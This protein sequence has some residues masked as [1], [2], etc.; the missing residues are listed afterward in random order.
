M[1]T[2]RSS[3]ILRLLGLVSLCVLQNGAFAAQPPVTCPAGAPIST[4]DLRVRSVRGTEPLPLRTINRL[5]EGDA[6][7]YSPI[8]HS[9]EKRK[10]E[11]SVVLVPAKR[12]PDGDKLLVLDPKPAE[13]SAEWKVPTK[14]SVASFVYGPDG[15]SQK[16]VKKF[17][18]KD[19][20]LVAQLADYAEKTAQTEALIQALSGNEHSSAGVDAALQG[21]ASQYGISNQLDRNAP[22]DQRALTLMRTLNPAMA[23]YDPLSSQSTQVFGQTASLA[24]SVAG[25]FFGS[26]VGL[27]AGGTAMVLTLRAMAFPNAEF[28]SSLAQTLPNEGMA[29]CGSRDPARPHTKV[30]YLWASRIPNIGPPQLSIGNADSLPV[31]VKSPLPIQTTDADWKYVDRA[32]EWALEGEQGQLIPVKIQRS[33]DQKSLELD[34]SNSEVPPG[35]YRLTARWDWDQFTTKGNVYMRP[36]SD[37]KAVKLAPESQDRL[38][39]NV[40][41]VP[42]TL[43]GSDFEF[44]TKVQIERLGDKF[45]SP[46]PIPFILPKGIRQGPQEKMDVQ[47][48]TDNL[49]P[50]PYRFLL[51]QVDGKTQS[52]PVGVLPAPPKV[53]NLP[54]VL[55]Q[56][57]DSRDFLLKGERLDLLTKLE[58]TNGTIE[59]APPSVGQTERKATVHLPDDLPKGTRSPI[60][61]YVKDRNEPLVFPDAIHVVGPRP[62]ITESK[63]SPPAGIDF[64]LNPGE[65]PAGLFLSTMLQVKNLDSDSVVKLTCDKDNSPQVALRVGERSSSASL[66]QLGSDQLF[67]SFGTDSWQN[68]CLINATIDN[69]GEGQSSPFPIGRVIRIP[70]IESFKLTDEESGKNYYVGVLTGRDLETI[71]KTGWNGSRGGSVLGLPTPIP[72]EGQRQSLRIRLPWPP[73]A[74]HAPLYVWFRGEKEGRLTAVRD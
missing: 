12:T 33:T 65:L 49:D 55:N 22:P 7:L 63:L 23:T 36:L 52:I 41:K 8:L 39:A 51:A 53:T 67:L 43:E 47:V 16:K 24:T 71:E 27:A 32:R 56:G 4:I 30:A 59:L 62:Q 72:G 11:V 34:L 14:I 37:F 9:N 61:A 29:L 35:K 45:A 25:M 66:Q 44:V 48:N 17:L 54:I 38:M 19:D 21:F 31:S 5:E 64:S 2:I 46:V 42:L 28:R 70:K 40:G 68:G 58:A 57:D 6:I 26:P 1:R 15:L 18:A 50:G 10:G 20:E 13:K 74:P 3:W 73:P 60:K 69:G